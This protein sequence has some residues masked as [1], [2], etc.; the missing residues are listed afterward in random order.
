M[1]MVMRM[2][3]IRKMTMIMIMSD[4][5]FNKSTLF[6]SQSHFPCIIFFLL[7]I[8]LSYDPPSLLFIH[9]RLFYWFMKAKDRL[10]SKYSWRKAVKR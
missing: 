5:K 10:L 3:M 7:N 2:M 6:Y 1:M 8:F 9:T 4:G